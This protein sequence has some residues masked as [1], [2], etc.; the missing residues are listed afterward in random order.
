MKSKGKNIHSC[1]RPGK[2]WLDTDGK[3]IHAHGGSILFAEG[4][5]WWYGE[6]KEGVYGYSMGE[7]CPYWHHGVKLYSSTDLYNWTDEGFCVQESDDA[8]NPF[9]PRHIMDRPHILFNEKTGNYVLWA[10][11]ARN[12]DFLTCKF[13]VCV[14]KSLKNMRF[15]KEVE[16]SP[17][18]AGDLDMFVYKGVAYILYENPHSELVV[19]ELSEDYTDVTEI[20]ST[21]F[22]APCPPF[23]REAPAV[24]ERKGR[25]YMLTSGTTGYFPNPTEVAD[26]TDIHGTWKNLGNACVNDKNNN[27][28]HSQFSSVFQHPTKEDVYI[29][30]G[31]R[32]LNDLAEDTPDICEAFYKV[33]GPNPQPVDLSGLTEENTSVATYVWLRVYF[34]EQDKPYLRWKRV[35]SI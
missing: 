8:D 11:T 33:F 32:W 22:H 27:S 24:F 3:W 9:Y 17:H 13:S 29:A 20:Y 5:Y 25:L 18:H 10:K 34:D 19:R 2:I 6:N 30:L 23:V 16:P 14:G 35:W 31:D 26:I 21:H 15:L 12:G 7:K 28:F 4:K 1:F